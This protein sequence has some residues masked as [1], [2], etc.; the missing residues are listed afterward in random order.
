MNSKLYCSMVKAN[1]KTIASYAIGS[2]LYLW[3]MIWV[4]PSMANAKGINEL[5]Q[6]MPEGMLK[7]FGFTG[8]FKI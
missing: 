5:I 7:A 3:L 1:G 4:Y 8:V 6:S 2:A